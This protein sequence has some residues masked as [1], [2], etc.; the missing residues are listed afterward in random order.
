MNTDGEIPRQARDDGGRATLLFGGDFCPIGRYENKILTCGTAFDDAL[1]RS[2]RGADFTMV[3]LEA[4]LCSSHIPTDN[5]DGSGLRADPRIAACLRSMGISAVGL[6]NNHIR[7]FR[8]DGVSQTIR[9]LEQN[10][11]LHTG[12]G[13]DLA[14]AQQPLRVDVHGVKVGIWAFAEKE[15]NV[16]SADRAGSSWFRPEADCARLE[17]MRKAFDFLVVF[18][19]AGHEF[20]HTPSPR[21]RTA[22][23]AL[24]DAGADAVIAHHPHVVQGV[25][26]YDGALIA[27]SIGNLVFDSPY[28]SAYEGTDLGFLVR[29]VVSRHRI[30]AAEFIPYRLAADTVVRTL[31][32]DDQTAFFR[33][34]RDLSENI[35]DDERFERAWE[36]NVRFRWET[37]YRKVLTTFSECFND[38]A[39]GDYARRAGNLLTCPTHVEMLEKVF[40]ML[41]E[42]R[43]SRDCTAGDE[44]R[45]APQ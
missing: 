33:T 5:A 38:P 11:V 35:T 2:F 23:R 13:M 25:E 36:E 37:E 19:H 6:A 17:E 30:D 21:I 28:V 16:A 3:N 15:L 18:L 24:V 12:A 44:S 22:C 10:G 7:D 8:D 14:A 1:G 34:L 4:P 27:Y 29:L 26:T 9:N 31:P 40:S 43:L 39:N 45:S 42:G 32:D 41:E 20:T